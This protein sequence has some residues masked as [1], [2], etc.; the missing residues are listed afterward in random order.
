MT[1]KELI[2]ALEAAEGPDRAL[3]AAIAVAAKAVPYDFEPAFMTA[4][5]RAIYDDRHWRAP[6]FTASIDAALTLVPEGA[7]WSIT[8]RGVKRGGFH[9][10]CALRDHNGLEWHEGTTPA[11]ALCIAALKARSS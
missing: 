4:E 11:I 7:F 1:D 3:D 9:A 5:W 8:M 10:C 6:D 2:A